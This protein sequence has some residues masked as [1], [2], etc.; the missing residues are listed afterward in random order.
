[1]P[2]IPTRCDEPGC[3]FH[4]APLIW[5][6]KAVPLVLDHINGV[7]GDNRTKNLRF[8]CPICNAQQPTHGGG[9]KGRV[10]QHEGGFSTKRKDG[11]RHYV[12]PAEPAHYELTFGSGKK[13]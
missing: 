6:E 5:N 12:L 13:A 11:K 1:L 8:L 10:E 4:Q 9:N 2:P 3:F 7:S